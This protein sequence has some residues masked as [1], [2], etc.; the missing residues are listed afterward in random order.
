MDLKIERYK[1]VLQVLKQRVYHIIFCVYTVLCTTTLVEDFNLLQPA[2]YIC[3]VGGGSA[4]GVLRIIMYV[5][6]SLSVSGVN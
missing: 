4:A 3:F 1:G 6:Q 5:I 2:T